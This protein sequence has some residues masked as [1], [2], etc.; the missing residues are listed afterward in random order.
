MMASM[1]KIEQGVKA[2]LL[3]IIVSVALAAFVVAFNP[4]LGNV[5]F[6]A[7]YIAAQLL[8]LVGIFLAEVPRAKAIKASGKGGTALIRCDSCATVWP[9]GTLKC[10]NCGASLA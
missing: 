10:G 3:S 9:A 4:W 6:T 1:G 8:F 5:G 2:F 7:I